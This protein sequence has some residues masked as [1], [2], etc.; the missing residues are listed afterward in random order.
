MEEW[1]SSILVSPLPPAE[2]QKDPGPV[3]PAV[4]GATVVRS[5][6]PSTAALWWGRKSGSGGG[7][8]VGSGVR[9]A[10]G[11][12]GDSAPCFGAPNRDCKVAPGRKFS[13]PE[14]RTVPTQDDG[15]R[16]QMHS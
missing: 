8:V 6:A 5:G 3:A 7:R 12:V 2:L 13:L 16:L 14:G 1:A 15:C 10:M 4:A 9:A 11:V